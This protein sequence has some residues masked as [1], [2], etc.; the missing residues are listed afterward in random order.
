MSVIRKGCTLL[1]TTTQL[2]AYL[3]AERSGIE[4]VY[5]FKMVE[6]IITELSLRAIPPTWYFAT[7]AAFRTSLKHSARV[8]D[9]E[10]SAEIVFTIVLAALLLF[11]RSVLA[12]A[13]PLVSLFM[14]RFWT[15]GA[16]WFVVG[17]LNANSA[18][19]GNIVLGSSITFG[20]MLLSL[21]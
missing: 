2:L 6:E 20:V 5:A 4:G 21:S 9:I 1:L 15:F 8:K 12:T 14:A 17:S 16:S 19:M 10:S 13:V 7:L 11:F 3:P 18:F